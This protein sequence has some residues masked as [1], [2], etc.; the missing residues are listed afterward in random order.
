MA[1]TTKRLLVALVAGAGL[2]ALCIVGVSQRVGAAGNELFLL[3]VWYNRLLMG[4][5]IGL[6]GWHSLPRGHLGVVLRGAT[7]GGLVALAGALS[8]GFRDLPSF[9]AGIVYGVLI[10]IAATRWGRR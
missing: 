5:V 9:F 8:T 10:D 6:A 1:K 2:G 3:A 7:L 4:L